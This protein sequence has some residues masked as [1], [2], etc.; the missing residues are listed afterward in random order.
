ML[1][2]P[3][4]SPRVESFESLILPRARLHVGGRRG[5][6]ERSGCAYRYGW[7]GLTVRPAEMYT[8][9]EPAEPTT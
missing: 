1:P 3:E 6:I 4:V 5:E 8:K 2:V 7:Y 9:L